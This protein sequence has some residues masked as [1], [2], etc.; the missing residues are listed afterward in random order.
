[1]C[2]AEG[3]AQRRSRDRE[4]LHERA[5]RDQQDLGWRG[6]HHGDQGPERDALAKALNE[7][8]I[9]TGFHYPVPLHMQECYRDWGYQKGSLQVTERVAS[10]PNTVRA[11]LVLLQKRGLVERRPHPGDKRMWRVSL[12]PSGRR[13]FRKLWRR[14]ESLRNELRSRMSTNDVA[15][16][17][18]LLGQLADSIGE[19]RRR[20]SQEYSI[21]D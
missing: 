2:T 14:T 6:E 16:L 20:P 19:T 11:M 13:V 15:T 3:V 7:K 8:G 18:G 21:A 4:A 5:R 17:V 9:H 10:D 1:M 12:T